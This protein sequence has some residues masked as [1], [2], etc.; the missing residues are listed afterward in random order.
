MSINVDQI[1]ESFCSHRF[2]VTYIDRCEEATKFL[3]TVATTF[4]KLKIYRVETCV[5]L[6][7]VG[8]TER[9]VS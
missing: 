6:E 7:G 5:V 8:I 9:T 4:T 1:V 3:E 2:A